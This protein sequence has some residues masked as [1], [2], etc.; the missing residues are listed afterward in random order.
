MERRNKWQGLN[1]NVN[2]FDSP[3]DPNLVGPTLPPIS[4]FTAPPGP[5]GATG[6]T[7]E[8]GSTGETGPTGPTG[9]VSPNSAHIYNVPGFS[10]IV[11]IPLDL[12]DNGVIVGTDIMHSPGTF[13]IILEGGH[14]YYVVYFLTYDASVGMAG[15]LQLN[16]LDVPGSG[17]FQPAA[18]GFT[19][20][21]E[22]SGGA[23]VTTPVG[24]PSTLS[25][26]TTGAQGETSVFPAGTTAQPNISIQ[27]IE[28]I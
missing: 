3:F 24:S 18:L 6:P 4:S 12:S 15:N 26:V 23:I 27:I 21:N 10:T 9:A 13:P 25:I 2:Q 16:G 11:G 28:L 8:T 1:F 5:T 22:S 19:G 17:Y 14:T 7:G 20:A